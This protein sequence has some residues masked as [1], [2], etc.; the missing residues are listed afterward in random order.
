MRNVAFCALLL[1]SPSLLAAPIAHFD[2]GGGGFIDDALAVSDDGKRLAFLTTDGATSAVLHIVTVGGSDTK[3]EG[4]PID[5]VALRW[6][7]SDRVLIVHGN[8]TGLRAV[9]F[10]PRGPDKQE[11][12]PFSRFAMARLDGK[13][14]LV[15]YTRSE[16]KGV[17]HDLVAYDVEHLKAV[18]KKTLTEDSEGKIYLPRGVIAPLWW[19][20][21]FTVLDARKPGE[22]DKAHDMRQPDRFVRLDVFGGKLL[23]DEEVKDVVAFTRVGLLRREH[24]NESVIVH[25]S[26]DRKQLLLL[27]KLSEAEVQLAR[28]IWK[29]DPQTLES[30]ILD[31]KRVA[32]SLT[33][34]PVNPDALNRQKAEPDEIDFYTVDRQSHAAARILTLP[35]EGRRSSWQLGGDRLFL[36]RKGKGFDRGGVML[37]V[38]ELGGGSAAVHR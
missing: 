22:Y 38:Y 28:P 33:V 12:G 24:P 19:S 25:F 6:L 26:D 35:G 5:V 29:Y 7:S 8:D 11:V 31:D 3:V 15:T 32:V 21:G 4:A 17:R 20:E 10:T 30:Q 2:A 34:D 23:S 9:A 36:L 18:K 1:L 16:K 27:D 37:E 13:P 14:V